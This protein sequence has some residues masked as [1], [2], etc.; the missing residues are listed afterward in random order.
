MYNRA[1]LKEAAKAQFKKNYVKAVIAAL[2]ITLI[3]GFAGGRGTRT[4]YNVVVNGNDVTVGEQ[5]FD[6]PSIL[7]NGPWND[8]DHPPITVLPNQN[9]NVHLSGIAALA[10]AAGIVFGILIFGTIGILIISLTI[11]VLEVGINR[12]FIKNAKAEDPSLGELGYGFSSD[13]GNVFKGYFLCTIYPFL[14][15]FLFVIP[16]IIKGYSY[17]LVPYI[18]AE[19]KV[20]AAEALRMSEALMRGHKMD[21]FMLDLSFIGWQIL[22]I[23]TAGLLGIFYVNPYV[24]QAKAD[25]YLKITQGTYG[26]VDPEY[27]AR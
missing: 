12:F 2:I 15:S 6:I 3:T 9:T 20:R 14:W 27:I 21:A 19:D 23:L 18:L 7:N 13:Y 24:S 1:E 5:D 11:G 25:F 4:T 16:G 22:N 8:M 17:Q 26:V 10:V